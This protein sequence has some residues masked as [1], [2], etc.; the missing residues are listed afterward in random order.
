MEVA[1]VEEGE[2]VVVV[3]VVVIVGLVV[4]VVVVVVGPSYGSGTSLLVGDV[5]SELL[6]LLVDVAVV[7]V[8]VSSAYSSGTSLMEADPDEDSLELTEL[9]LISALL[10]LVVIIEV[11]EPGTIEEEAVLDQLDVL[12]PSGYIGGPAILT[13]MFPTPTL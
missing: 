1:E 5:E 10:L 11:V 3:V 12:E 2:E 6:S 4:V 13:A 8:V 7:V 9:E